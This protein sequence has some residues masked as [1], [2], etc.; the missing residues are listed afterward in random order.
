MRAK[1]DCFLVCVEREVAERNAEQIHF[2]KVV[3][4]ITILEDSQISSS[5]TLREIARKAEARYTLLVTK[6][7][8]L[9][10]GQYAV[11]R[12]LR[13]AHD[14]GAVMVYSDYYEEKAGKTARHPVIDY[15]RGSLRDDLDFGSVIMVRTD[16]F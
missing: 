14:T 9:L 8:P 13:A 16:L 5:E 4:N 10:M 7:T 6:P 12:M 2:D 15:Q 11:E 3:N 1:I